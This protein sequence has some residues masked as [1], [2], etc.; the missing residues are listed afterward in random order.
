MT[1]WAATNA[2]PSGE[3][4]ELPFR[5]FE[6]APM[7][8]VPGA[9]TSTPLA[10]EARAGEGFVLPPGLFLVPTKLPRADFRATMSG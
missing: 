6:L 7:N 3:W 10:R 1:M 5:K 2:T 9:G 4:I 8:E